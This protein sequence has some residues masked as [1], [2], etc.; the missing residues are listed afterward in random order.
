MSEICKA[1]GALV[2]ENDRLWRVA[3]AL[4][5]KNYKIPGSSN[6]QHFLLKRL[7]VEK[8]IDVV[9]PSNAFVQEL[10]ETCINEPDLRFNVLKNMEESKVKFEYKPT[11]TAQS[12]R[13]QERQDEGHGGQDAFGNTDVSDQR[14]RWYSVTELSGLICELCVREMQVNKSKVLGSNSRFNPTSCVNYCANWNADTNGIVRSTEGRK[15]YTRLFAECVVTIPDLQNLMVDVNNVQ[16]MT[17]II[18][19]LAY[20]KLKKELSHVGFVSMTMDQAAQFYNNGHGKQ[21]CA[22]R[23]VITCKNSE[24]V[25]ERTS[26]FMIDKDLGNVAYSS[27]TKSVLDQGTMYDLLGQT[28]NE[29]SL[30]DVVEMILGFFEVMSYFQHELPLWKDVWK[31]KREFEQS[32]VRHLAGN[33][34]HTTGQNR[35]RN[36][37]SA[38]LGAPTKEVLD[39]MNKIKPRHPRSLMNEPAT[40]GSKRKATEGEG[41]GLGQAPDPSRSSHPNAEKEEQKQ[42]ERWEFV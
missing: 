32:I 4:T 1:A 37:P 23:D 2:T 15:L 27:W 41:D 35:K 38:Q 14:L 20:S 13:K 42:R 18:R 31:I 39:I 5:G 26:I 30:G 10:E 19:E 22:S 25:E 28:S 33:V 34:S 21:L 3:H 29:E 40:Q 12:K 36:K 6:L 9:A 7:L 17:T 8:S 16:A 24:G 11:F